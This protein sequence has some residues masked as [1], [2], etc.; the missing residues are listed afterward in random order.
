MQSINMQIERLE[1]MLDSLHNK[2]QSM[3][4]DSDTITQ[5]A[6]KALLLLSGLKYDYEELQK[7]ENQKEVNSG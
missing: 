5:K 3:L 2:S 4:G 1:G 6:L 7:T